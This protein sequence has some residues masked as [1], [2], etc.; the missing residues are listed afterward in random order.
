MIKR[1]LR[2]HIRRSIFRFA[3]LMMPVVGAMVSAYALGVEPRKVDYNER[4]MVL[5]R[6]KPGFDGYRIIQ[7]SDLHFDSWIAAKTMLPQIIERINEY[8]ADLIVVTG[9]FVSSYPE[10]HIE[11]LRKN[12]SML[13]AKDGVLAVMGNHDHWYNVG[14]L[15]EMLQDAGLKEL[16][17][18]V[19]SIQRDDDYLHIAGIEDHWKGLSDVDAI[20]EQIDAEHC[21]ILLA[22]E[23]DYADISSPTGRFDL[24]LSGHSH[25]G[26]INLPFTGAPWLP[27]YGEKYPAGHYRIGNMQLYTNRGLGTT[28]L[29]IRFN[30]PPE[31]SIFTLRSPKVAKATQFPIPHGTKVAV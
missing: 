22:H 8:N 2:R 25:G 16:R 23:P 29:P 6:L 24:Q 9:D 14:I 18:E 21:A 10:N 5:P 7:I 30:C 11:H 12:L 3:G 1:K 20:V 19:F 4:D 31:V 15:R 27:R 13:K 26:Q 17:N 28:M